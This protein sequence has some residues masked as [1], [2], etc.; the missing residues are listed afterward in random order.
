MVAAM[1]QVWIPRI[2]GPDVLE[3]REAPDPEPGAGEVRVRVEAAGINFAD[4]MARMGLYPDAPKLPTVVGYEASGVVDAIGDGVTRVAVGDRVMGM[5]RFGGYSDVVVI[6]EGQAI[7][8]GDS[9]SFETAAAI[10]V[11]YLTAWMML[12]RLGN[13]QKGERVLIHSAGGGVGLAA[14]QMAVWRGAEIYGT[15][16]AGKHEQLKAAGVHHCI[17]YRNQDFQ[18]EIARLTD[19]KGVHLIIDAVG[20]DSFKKSYASLATMGR[21]FLFGASSFA[22]GKKRS[23]LAAVR[24]FMA[25]PKFKPIP[26]M[27]QN[28]GVFGVNLG[29][30]WHLTA[31][32][33]EMLTEIVGLVEQ[34]VFTPVVDKTFPFAEAADAHRYIQ[35]RK[36]YGK[37]LLTP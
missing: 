15:A 30:M 37:V 24:G 10:P 34:G 12:I 7:K 18:A 11:Q 35:D 26:L 16:S 32:L 21:L 23:I 17:D 33:T 13:L 1:Q 9:V 4:I 25:L 22:P 3:V 6:P 19:G 29:H 36:N 31:E 14:I 8:I 20:G 28:R 5:T 27:D 2:G